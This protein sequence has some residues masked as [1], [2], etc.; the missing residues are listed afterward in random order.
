MLSWVLV[1]IP[2]RDRESDELGFSFQIRPRLLRD[3]L[4]SLGT[5]CFLDRHP[6]LVNSTCA[7]QR[8]AEPGGRGG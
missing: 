2:E 3:R 4:A 1:Q 8:E 7:V 5:G 6:L